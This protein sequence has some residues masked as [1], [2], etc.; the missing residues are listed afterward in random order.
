MIENLKE[1]MRKN[2]MTREQQEE[3]I[4]KLENSG[5]LKNVFLTVGAVGV[6]SVLGVS[7]YNHNCCTTLYSSASGTGANI[8]EKAKKFLGLATVTT[9][10][11]VITTVTN[12][13]TTS[14]S[15]NR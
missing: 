12:S 2:N 7:L 6:V 9:A 14:D 11:A 8:F 4:K 1:E 3:M 5:F 15:L 13:V 10:S